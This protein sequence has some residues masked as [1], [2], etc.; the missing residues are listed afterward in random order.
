VNAI[1]FGV[2]THT[3]KYIASDNCHS[4][5]R[6]LYVTGIENKLEGLPSD[7]MIVYHEDEVYQIFKLGPNSRNCGKRGLDVDSTV[8]SDNIVYNY[9]TRVIIPK[10]NVEAHIFN[11]QK[12]WNKATKSRLFAEWRVIKAIEMPNY[13]SFIIKLPLIAIVHPAA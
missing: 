13:S 12:T 4:Y 10:I 8:N 3:C 1:N 9:I 6:N 11:A 5:R 7:T 2:M